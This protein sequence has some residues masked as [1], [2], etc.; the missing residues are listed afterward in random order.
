MPKL[1]QVVYLFYNDCSVNSTDT[2]IYGCSPD[3]QYKL[4]VHI[5]NVHIMDNNSRFLTGPL[6]RKAGNQNAIPICLGCGL[7]SYLLWNFNDN[8][9]V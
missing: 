9:I 6:V 1:P 4:K 5:Q 3:K 8:D 7:A 2:T